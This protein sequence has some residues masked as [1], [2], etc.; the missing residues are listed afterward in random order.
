[1]IPSPSVKI[2]IM[3]VKVCWRCKG[4][5][6]QVIFYK[7]LKIKSLLTS[8]SNVLPYYLKYMN[9]HWRWRWWDW[10]Q[11]I[12]LNLFYFIRKNWWDHIWMAPFISKSMAVGGKTGDFCSSRT[13]V[14]CHLGRRSFDKLF[15]SLCKKVL[16]TKREQPNQSRCVLD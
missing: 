10:I 5:S 1:M 11:A 12:F 9:F 4:K 6:L 2:Q 15:L 8:P 16:P 7:L 14:S 3:A 13:I